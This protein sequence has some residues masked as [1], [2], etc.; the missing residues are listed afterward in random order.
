MTRDS[1]DDCDHKK[2]PQWSKLG[3]VLSLL[4]L[5]VLVVCGVAGVILVGSAALPYRWGCQLRTTH[6]AR[7]TCECASRDHRVAWGELAV[8]YWL[9]NVPK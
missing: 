3:R 1:R 7:Q 5:G 4:S 8:K 6:T 9:E 2:W